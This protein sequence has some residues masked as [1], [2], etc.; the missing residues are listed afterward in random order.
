M[1]QPNLSIAHEICKSFDF[2]YVTRGFFL[3]IMKKTLFLVS[4][5]AGIPQG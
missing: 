3:D 5:T 2:R 4:V 1:Y